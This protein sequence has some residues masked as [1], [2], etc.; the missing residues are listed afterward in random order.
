MSRGSDVFTSGSGRNKS[1]FEEKWRRLTSNIDIPPFCSFECDWKL[2][3]AKMA[4]DPVQVRK[5]F[6]HIC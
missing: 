3:K 5:L 1:S 2:L 6:S 4:A